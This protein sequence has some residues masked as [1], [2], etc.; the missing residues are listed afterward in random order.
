MSKCFSTLYWPLVI[1]SQFI[2]PLPSM[3]LFHRSDGG[4]HSKGHTVLPQKPPVQT[5]APGATAAKR[6]DESS[7]ALLPLIFLSPILTGRFHK[8]HPGLLAC[9]ICIHLQ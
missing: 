7:S 4:I 9:P 8:H 5:A 2:T 6:K 1:S 3:H